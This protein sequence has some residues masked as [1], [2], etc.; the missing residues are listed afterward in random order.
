MNH[1]QLQDLQEIREYPSLS[2]I[3]PTHRTSPDNLQ[4][5]IRVKNMVTETTKKLLEEFPGRDVKSLLERLDTLVEEIDWPHTLDG[6]A[7]FVNKDYAARFDLPFPVKGH[8]L[9][10]EGFATRDLVFAMNRN[11]R[12]WVLVLSTHTTRLF[13]ATRDHLEEVQAGGFPLEHPGADGS[14]AMPG[15]HGVQQPNY[16]DEYD[17]Q[18]FHK[19]DAG[20]THV[21]AA[22]PLPVV[23]TGVTRNLALWDELSSNKSHLAGTHDGSYEGATHHELGLLVWPVMQEF[24]AKHRTEVLQQLDAAIGAQK[25]AGGIDEVWQ[26]AQEGRGELLVVEEDFHYMGQPNTEGLLMPAATEAPDPNFAGDAVDVL[27]ETVLANHGRVEFVDNGKLEA[28]G[29]IALILRW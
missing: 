18:F 3:A 2:I 24:M 5:P 29:R 14:T 11:P 16:R 12:Y 22:N 25:Y 23:V 15:G 1:K 6:V 21:L 8:F 4:D 7:L 13:K 9:I 19:I 17:R 26:L 20:L 28:N 27:I 10:D